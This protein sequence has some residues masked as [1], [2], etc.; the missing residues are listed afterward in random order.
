MKSLF[1]ILTIFC[2]SCASHKKV[3]QPKANELDYG[4]RLFDPRI[5][6][7]MPIDTTK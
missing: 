2:F 6:H 1:V 4:A 7:Y 5:G 3:Q